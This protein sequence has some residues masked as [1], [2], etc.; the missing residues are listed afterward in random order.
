MDEHWYEIHV[1][2]ADTLYDQHVQELKRQ[3]KKE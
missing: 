3:E 1:P 2:K